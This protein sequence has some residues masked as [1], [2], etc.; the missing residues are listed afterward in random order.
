MC[1]TC[2]APWVRETETTHENPG[3]RTTNGQRSVENRAQTAGFEVRREKRVET[4]GWRASCDCAWNDHRPATVLDPFGGSGTVGLVAERLQRDAVLIEI[5][6]AYAK[7][8]ETRIREDAPL[9]TDVRVER[10]ESVAI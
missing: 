5:S 7:M 2:G 4:T 8:A 6:D 1:A 3:N 9:L 10:G